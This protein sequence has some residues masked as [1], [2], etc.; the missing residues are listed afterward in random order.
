MPRI[1]RYECPSCAA[2]FEV[3]AMTAD[4]PPPGGPE[5][6]ESGPPAEPGENG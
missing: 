2:A 6:D 1:R 4:E 3:F 5:G